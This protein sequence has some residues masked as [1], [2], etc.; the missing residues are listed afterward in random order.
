MPIFRV[1]S[2]KI[3]T[4]QKKFTRIYPWDPWQISGM[5]CSTGCI[6][7]R[8]TLAATSAVS[9]LIRAPHPQR[10]TYL[11][12]FRT[13][14]KHSLNPLFLQ[15]ACLAFSRNP[16]LRTS[17]VGS[18]STGQ[19]KSANCNFAMPVFCPFSCPRPVDTFYGTV[20]SIFTIRLFS[21]ELVFTPSP[22]GCLVDRR[23]FYG[24]A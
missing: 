17:D 9:P 2:V 24:S 1:K 6:L 8:V 19:Q 18:V 20:S 14:A 11:E 7:Q 23:G 13:R 3:Y 16:I 22:G 21:I 10:L 5:V 12:G 15:A 4:G